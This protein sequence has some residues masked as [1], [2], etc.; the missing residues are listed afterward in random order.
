MCAALRGCHCKPHLFIESWRV[1]QFRCWSYC[2]VTRDDPSGGS[3]ACCPWTHGE[4]RHTNSTGQ[5]ASATRHKLDVMIQTEWLQQ[6]CRAAWRRIHAIN[7][8]TV[9]YAVKSHYIFIQWQHTSVKRLACRGGS[10][11]Q[12]GFN[13]T[14]TYLSGRSLTLAARR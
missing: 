10:H 1:F 8:Q 2:Q 13:H 6:L 9:P 4:V 14:C 7:S 11:H 12:Y 3:G 5:Y